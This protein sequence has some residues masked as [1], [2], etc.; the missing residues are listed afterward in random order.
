[1]PCLWDET[2]ELPEHGKITNLAYAPRVNVLP[3]EYQFLHESAVIFD[4]D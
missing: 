1:M 3:G 2:H 4:G